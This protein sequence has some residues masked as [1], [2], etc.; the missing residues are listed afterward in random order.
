MLILKMMLDHASKNDHRCSTS[1]H[2]FLPFTNQ[3]SIMFAVLRRSVMSAEA[4]LSSLAT[5][6]HSSSETSQEW[7]P[8]DNTVWDLNETGMKLT[9]QMAEWYRAS[10]S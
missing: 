4:H 3:T 9:A 2:K 8:V 1:K 6:Q 10:V 7:R 5:G